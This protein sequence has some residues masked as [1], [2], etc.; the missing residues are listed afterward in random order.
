MYFNMV[1]D[2]W[3]QHLLAISCIASY[4]TSALASAVG[5]DGKC[6]AETQSEIAKWI[7]ERMKDFHEAF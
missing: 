3:N 2:I 4:N 1:I 6:L 7:S 5:D